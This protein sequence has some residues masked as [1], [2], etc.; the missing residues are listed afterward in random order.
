MN[1]RI[2]VIAFASFALNGQTIKKEAT[3]NTRYGSFYFYGIVVQRSPCRFYAN[4]LNQTSITW[5][6]PLFAAKA[7]GLD[8]SGKRI[9]FTITIRAPD[10]SANSREFELAHGICSLTEDDESPKVDRLSISMMGG[11]PDKED[12]AAFERR[13]A[14]RKRDA[15]AAAASTAARNSRLA[16]LPLITSGGESAFIGSDR[17]CA[18]QFQQALAMDGLEKRK[19]FADLISFGCGFLTNSPARAVIGPRDGNYVA[20]TLADGKQEGKSGWVPTSWLH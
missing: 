13:T 16:K 19:R 8:S 7:S 14:A 15:E 1:R 4:V 17:K 5:E 9:T 18:E 10:L 11:T 6:K 20:V 12:L 2:F 3:V